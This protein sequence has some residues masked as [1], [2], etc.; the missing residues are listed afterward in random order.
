MKKKAKKKPTI[1]TELEVGGSTSAVL[2]AANEWLKVEEAKAEE[3]PVAGW[4]DVS[5]EPTKLDKVNDYAGYLQYLAYLTP[6]TAPAAIGSQVAEAGAVSASGNTQRTGINAPST[7][8]K[9]AYEEISDRWDKID[10]F[11]LEGYKVDPPN[12]LKMT[13]EYQH[14]REYWAKFK[15]LWENG[16][17]KNPEG[18]G[19]LDLRG[20]QID[21][22]NAEGIA[23]SYG[24]PG[25]FRAPAGTQKD[26][27]ITEAQYRQQHQVSVPT[28]EQQSEALR[29]AQQVAD[30]TKPP[31][32]H[33]TWWDAIPLWAKLLG[34]ALVVGVVGSVAMPYATLGASMLHR[35]HK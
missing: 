10:A 22:S 14:Q 3:I 7:F 21:E 25:Q 35:R 33:P 12:A 16:S 30:A 27:T 23:S 32:G 6:F 8:D 17:D 31:A 24:F 9:R 28:T 4:F 2:D 11:A 18:N 20:I 19:I 1:A 15:A 13:Q 5:G 26:R 34:G 29:L